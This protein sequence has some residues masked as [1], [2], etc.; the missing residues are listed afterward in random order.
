MLLTAW[1]KLT[2][3]KKQPKLC[4]QCRFYMSGEERKNLPPLPG[5]AR[6]DTPACVFYTS[7]VSGKRRVIDCDRA[8]YA[9]C[10][11]ANF[12]PKGPS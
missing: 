2:R 9:L 10:R 1:K 3:R 5:K 11:G 8:R 4:I 6:E 12:E 7:D